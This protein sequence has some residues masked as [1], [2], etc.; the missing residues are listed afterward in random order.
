MGKNFRARGIFSG[1]HNTQL[2]Q[3]GQIDESL[4]IASGAGITVPIPDTAKVAGTV[5]E[6]DIGKTRLAQLRADQQSSKSCAD[7]C[8]L[9][10]IGQWLAVPGLLSLRDFF[11][12]VMMTTVDPHK[13]AKPLWP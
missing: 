6:T 9:N 1:R 13:L 11:K 12:R 2:F 8:N 7:H 10:I 5:D 4:G 3:H